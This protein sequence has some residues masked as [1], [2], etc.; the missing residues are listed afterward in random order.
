MDDFNYF[1]DSLQKSKCHICNSGFTSRNKPTLD[2]KNNKIGHTKDNVRWCCN[3]CNSVKAYRDEAYTKLFIQLRRFQIKYHLPTT[4]AKG[5]EEEYRVTRKNI[6][7]GLSNVH[8]RK[9]IKGVNTIKN[10]EYSD[11]KVHIIDI[12]SIITHIIGIDFNTLYPSSYS[13][14]PHPSNPYTDRIMYM[15]GPLKRVIKNEE[16]AMRI[17]K[18]RKEI[19]SVDVKGHIDNRYLN[20][21][22]RFP[23][24]FINVDIITN[25]E[26]IGESMYEY[27]ILNSM[28]V[29]KKERK[30]TQLTD[31]HNKYRLTNNYML[32]FLI[33]TYH[34]IIDL[35][36][37]MD[38]YEKHTGFRTFTEEMIRVRQEAK[39]W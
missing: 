9:N 23:P 24:I 13:S 21:V 36:R 2:R 16:V 14:L 11:D 5:D 12:N 37:V 27:M 39:L 6:T 1:R 15:P 7:G 25:K 18:E 33:D 4:L 32:W 8:N 26:P 28:K 38:V 19:F 30:L 29:D 34:F 20:E 3:Y 31:T 10:L 17:I 22:V 35:I